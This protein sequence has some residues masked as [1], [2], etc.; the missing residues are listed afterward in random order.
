MVRP[1]FS[2]CLCP[3]SYLVRVHINQTLAATPPEKANGLLGS[4][5]ATW[6][7][8]AF[9][10]D[11]PL[12]DA[13]W[14]HLALQGLFGVPKV[15]VVH[16]A[17]NIPADSWKKISAALAAPNRETWP[18]F[19]LLA[20][21]E[22]GK[23]KLPAH[24]TKL[25]CFA[26]A[27]KKGWIWSS[28]GLDEKSKTPFVAAEAKRRNLVF[29]P[30]ALEAIASRLPTDATAIGAELDKLALAASAEGVLDKKLADILEREIDPDVFALIR[31]LQQ[32]RNPLA[33]W[34]QIFASER[35]GESM[36][37]AFFAMLARE[38][39][40]LWQI[41]HG[42]SVRMPPQALAAKT[43]LARMLGLGGTA[44]LWH[45]ALDADKSIK[46]GERSVDQALENILASL[47]LLFLQPGKKI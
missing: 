41:L 37:F 33:A 5:A 29:G 23:P 36:A 7:R 18:F 10:G 21:F 30:G 35:S 19:C 38:A 34:E 8:H 27:E 6:E 3:D 42:E 9:W 11:D 39:R 32:G 43:T 1:G 17:Q 47:S 2:I 12:P 46:T 40:Q 14:E 13:F 4:G 25:Q 15:V 44:K 45:L 31:A 24:I 22:R 16:N 28:P 26:F 20:P